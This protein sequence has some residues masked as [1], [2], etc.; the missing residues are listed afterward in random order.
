MKI[1]PFI[2]LG[3][4][5][6]S[7]YFL[8]LFLIV[9]F[10]NK[11]TLFFSPVAKKNYTISLIIP[12][13]NEGKTIARTIK[14]IF[15]IDYPYI[16][17]VIVVNDGS[18]DNTKEI[19]SKLLKKYSKLK[20]IN[21]K[22][23]LG[24]AAKSQNV[25]LKYATG[26]L[27][28]VLDADSYPS[29][30][31]IKKMVGWFN[32]SRVGVVTCP[33][34]ADNQNKFIEKLQA[35]EYYV[36]ALTRKLLDYL[37]AIYV[38]PGTLAIYRAKALRQIKGFDE[39]NMTQDIEATWHLTHNGWDRRMSLDT[40]VKTTV[41]STW[42]TWFKQRRR[43]NIGGLQCIWK[44]KSNFLKKGMLG[45]FILPFFVL[46][47]F[48]GLIG[49]SIFF[50]LLTR[51]II[52]RYIFTKYTFEAGTSLI[53]FKDLYI[54]PSFLNYLGVI[55][56]ILGTIFTFSIL[57]IMKYRIMTKQNIF[58]IFFFMLIYLTIYPFIMIDSIYHTIMKKT[59][60]R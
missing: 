29:K 47:L 58:N 12:A 57:S 36:I 40:R 15:E 35:I 56:F 46:Q 11:K 22:K 55:L 38:A 59:I 19:V 16:K 37:D 48:L 49:L 21:N 6:V 50:Y 20:L 1:L 60:W 25:G 30:D 41:M 53:T 24:N 18:T 13:Y 3:Y 5:F 51:N 32:D 2:Y 17:E 10:R 4:M 14:S 54:T 8:S 43:W 23:N 28:A 26:E 31:S 52:S 42:K 44:Y 27:I 34:E 7:L 9:Y 39:K 33:S 45:F